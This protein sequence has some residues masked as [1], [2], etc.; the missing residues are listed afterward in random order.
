M[1]AGRVARRAMLGSWW[2]VGWLGWELAA[3]GAE[4]P[5]AELSAV[6]PEAAM[7][8]PKVDPWWTKLRYGFVLLSTV[9][10]Q[11]DNG[12]RTEPFLRDGAGRF[13]DRD[14]DGLPDINGNW[15]PSG[16]DFGDLTTTIGGSI[17]Y[18]RW[19][20]AARFDTVFY[21]HRPV[22]AP[23]ASALIERD[24]HDRYVNLFRAE[25]LALSYTGRSF[26]ATLGD[27]YMTLGRG[28]ILSLRKSGDVGVDNKL[29]GAKV[30]GRFGGVQLLAFGGFVNGKNYEAGTGYDYPEREQDDDPAGRPYEAN[31]LVVGGRAAYRYTRYVEVGAHAVY[32]R[33][34]EDEDGDFAEVTGFGASLELPRPV[35][36]LSMYF[37]AVGLRRM[38]TRLDD[39]ET[40]WG[41][42][43]TASLYLGRLTAL[44]EGKVYDHLFNVFPRGIR[45]PRR[46]V[47]NR[48]VEPPTAER[49]LTILLANN[50]VTGGRLR[51]DW[52]IDDGIV[53][54]LAGGLYVDDSFGQDPSGA[55]L[56]GVPET[57]I[58]AV[59][60]GARIGGDHSEV[61]WEM[62]FRGQA[63]DFDEDARGLDERERARRSDLDG[64]TFR[65]DL[66]LLIDYSQRL[67]GPLT[68]EVVLNG[69]KARQG[70]GAAD[71]GLGS[72]LPSECAGRRSGVRFVPI[73]DDWYEGRLALSLKSR[74]GYA[75]TGAW[76]FYTRQPDRFDQHYFSV[77]AQW[78]FMP[79][80]TLRGLYGAERAGLKCSGG[81]CR[82]FPGFEG[83]R[84]EL[85]MNL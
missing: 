13:E 34:P 70:I 82:F 53:P 14:G 30:A 62:G 19:L 29:R 60:G 38:D 56:E 69:A 80:S 27:F 10:W 26:E 46:Q 64:S 44:L 1:V 57:R 67:W 24:L 3:R 17:G 75:M 28:L 31:D 72:E 22:A 78:E 48:Y 71:C 50:T 18:E 40:G 33:S 73:H 61:L 16:E 76:E 47:I 37:E 42:Y 54:Y 21:A 84:L 20:L 43:G 65:D 36:W 66:H 49:P 23:E 63:N 35:S 81:V 83:G 11:F 77:G 68:A 25:Y 45:Q 4:P 32:I 8:T 59:Y 15:N 39:I 85:S 7:V 52:R 2:I 9:R 74:D 5:V 6:E 58:R 12:D 41:L 55:D 51:L 79:G